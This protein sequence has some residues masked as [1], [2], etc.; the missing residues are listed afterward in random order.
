MNVEKLKNS[1]SELLQYLNDNG[2][3]KSYIQ[4]IK[5]GLKFIMEN[6]ENWDG[7]TDSLK[8]YLLTSPTEEQLHHFKIA[9][10]VWARFDLYGKYPDRFPHASCLEP[11]KEP[12][13][14]EFK[15]TLSNYKT[16]ALNRGIKPSS[17]I[18]TFI[19]ATNFFL[20]LEDLNI[21]TLNAIT[22]EAILTIL[23]D[24]Q[25][26]PKY[27][28][29]Y[30]FM[31]R[32]VFKENTSEDIQCARLVNMVPRLKKHRKNIQFFNEEE[33]NKLKYV[34]NKND[35]LSLRDKAIGILLFYTGLRASDIVA[36]Q[37][38][39]IDW[40]KDKIS[41]YQQKTS[42]PLELPLIPIVGNAIYDYIYN[43]RHHSSDPHIFLN[44]VPPFSPMR[45]GYISG[46]S[47]NIYKAAEI[48]Q[49]KGSKRGAHL[50]RHNFATTLLENGS[51]RTVIT[52]LLGHCN[53]QST[54]PYI[55]ADMKHLRKC[56]LSIDAY[57]VKG[58]FEND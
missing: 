36:L 42:M 9:M 5:H 45:A 17:V 51:S 2:Y 38:D 40:E 52:N 35:T 11:V 41:I 15:R 25:G 8:Q 22:E 39:S 13:S 26:N 18:A 37:F 47:N 48:R 53:P 1:K 7:Y 54:I 43:E 55:S 49:T 50:F 12:T 21:F 6:A 14:S 19:N 33:R 16:L 57:P 44:S 29:T 58:V 4:N 24:S 46:I 32:S 3:S 20:A 27:S 31:I 56:A 34:L 10:N 28:S 30:N 23:T